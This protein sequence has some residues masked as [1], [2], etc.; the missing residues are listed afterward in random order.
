MHGFE[1]LGQGLVEAEGRTGMEVTPGPDR[2][3]SCNILHSWRVNG[4]AGSRL[5]SELNMAL[6]HMGPR[7]FPMIGM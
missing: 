4:P 6:L 2:Q 1:F 7:C 3:E 5:L